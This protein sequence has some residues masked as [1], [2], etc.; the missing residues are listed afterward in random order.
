[1]SLLVYTSPYIADGSEDQ[2]DKIRPQYFD[3]SINYI[4]KNLCLDLNNEV[5]IDK[6]DFLDFMEIIIPWKELVNYI[7]NIPGV[8]NHENVGIDT[9][10][11]IYCMQQWFD[12]DVGQIHDQLRENKNFSKFAVGGNY[13]PGKEAIER[14]YNFIQT[15]KIIKNNIYF[16]NVAPGTAPSARIL[17]LLGIF[18]ETLRTEDIWHSVLLYFYL[19]FYG[20]PFRNEPA[21]NPEK[22]KIPSELLAIHQEIEGVFERYFM[23]LPLDEDKCNEFKKI[24]YTLIALFCV[25]INRNPSDN[26]NYFIQYIGIHHT[27]DQPKDQDSKNQTEDD[28]YQVKSKS[29]GRGKNQR[30]YHYPIPYNELLSY[31]MISNG[32]NR[33]MNE[34]YIRESY[35][36][37]QITKHRIGKSN[38]SERLLRP[39]QI[40]QMHITDIQNQID[41]DM[42]SLLPRLKRHYAIKRNS[43]NQKNTYNDRMYGSICAL[44]NEATKQ[45]QQDD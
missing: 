2:G 31:M 20:V 22:P 16:A 34:Q 40:K 32:R 45:P 42:E 5:K 21:V 14:F 43:S 41:S 19:R 39:E 11:R 38:T 10:L 35:R 4:I 25:F 36:L 13:I 26:L 6:N 3:K 18:R 9:M 44:V 30:S 15:K 24:I 33:L 23:P 29:R 12:K 37:I 17:Y 8:V 1:M 7:K 27:Q 28:E